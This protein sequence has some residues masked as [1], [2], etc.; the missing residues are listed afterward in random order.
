MTSTTRTPRVAVVL[1]VYNGERYLVESVE[2]VLAQTFTDFELVVV[3]DGST[4]HT[5]EILAGF[6]DPRVRVIR[7]PENRGMV[8]AL[9]TGI[10]ESQSELIA[11]MDADDICVPQRFERQ[12]EFLDAHPNVGLCGTWTQGFGEESSLMRPPVTPERIRAR[13][14]FGWAMD[15]PSLLMRRDVLQRHEL[16][17]DDR[18]RHVEDFDLF[19][20]AAEVTELANVSQILLHTRAHPEEVSV[21][22]RGEQ[23]QTEARLFARQ[24]RMLMP[25]AT[26]EEE[27][28]HVRLATG[29]LDASHCAEA[30]QWLL[31]LRRANRERGRYDGT[32]FQLELQRKWYE[33]HALTSSAGLR[34][35]LSYWKS[36]LASIRDVRL[37]DHAGLIAR[38]LVHRPG[39]RRRLRRVREQLRAVR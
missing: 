2:S 3:D 14:F 1:P 34:V 31:R 6:R 12:V 16:A 37:R 29:A 8:T 38:C 25:D 26:P 36:P 21:R 19:I 30:G 7:F 27:E 23:L 35:L 15:H 4:D 18:F 22:H 10:R 20:R 13:L 28:F 24:L 5:A 17:Y 32:A 33:L 39:W 11:R 9:N